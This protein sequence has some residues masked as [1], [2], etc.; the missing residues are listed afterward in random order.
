[1][2]N[3]NRLS[4]IRFA[5]ATMAML[6]SMTAFAQG[7]FSIKLRLVD[8]KSA[9]PVSFATVSIAEK[10][11]DKA[12]K[13][14]LSDSEGAAE[15]VKVK[16]GTY[17]LK[18]ELMGYH[19]HS[20]EVVLTKD[21]NLGEIKL[22]EDVKVL[23]AASVSAIGN[24]IVVKKDTIEYTASS[25]K[26]SDNDMLEE[27]LKKLPGVEV[28]AD[29]SITANGE[30]IKKITIDGKTFFLDDPQL[31]SKNI[32]A[33]L[34]EK[35]KVVEKKSDQAMFTGIDDGEEETIIDLSMK[36]GMMQGWF[37]NLMG[38]GGH[39][40][41]GAGSDMN[42]WR[43]QGAAM[44]GRFTDKSQISV[45]LNGNN[46]NNR[47]FNDM[48]GSMM[49]G[50]RGGGGGMGRGMGGWGG[51]NGITTSWMGGLNGAFSLLDGDMDL[52]GNYLYNG[53]IK[54]VMEES[55]KITYLED[56]SRLLNNQNGTDRTMTQGHRFGVRLEHKFSENTSILF[57]PQVNFG[58]GSY[59]EYSDF[60]QA[61]CSN[62]TFPQ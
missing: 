7:S 34:I 8:A 23:D 3:R 62:R 59:N 35:V 47:G 46:T 57:E 30:T 2:E 1:M 6:L 37:G 26:T 29:G 13:Y 33:K 28:E 43:Y 36:P 44:V 9:E 48:A 10:G 52:S 61:G 54:D 49:Q 45:I 56:G 11:Q 60:E 14:V 50:M 38:G 15:I 19:T 20:Q 12:L 53:S 5:L 24:P 18:A 32:P 17:I 58:K 55:S 16:K 42:D 40:L 41:P 21:I 22:S 4:F 39:D 51:N 27:L 25:F 31:A